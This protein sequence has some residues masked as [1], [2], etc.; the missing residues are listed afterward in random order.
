MK[1]FFILV[2]VVVAVCAGILIMVSIASKREAKMNQDFEIIDTTEVCAEALEGIYSDNIYEYFLPCIKSQNITIKFSDGRTL[3]LKE[4]IETE[5]VTI[6]QLQGKG[7]KIY[8]ELK[9]K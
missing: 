7:L 4:A 8:K 2:C 1:R 5:Q 3:P 9:V 6:N